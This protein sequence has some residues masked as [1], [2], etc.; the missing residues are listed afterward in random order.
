MTNLRRFTGSRANALF[1]TLAYDPDSHLFL[2]D[3][4]S[5]AFGYLCEPLSAADQSNADRLLVLGNLDWPPETLLQVALWT[6]PDVEETVARMEG[7][8]IET[9]TALLREST[10]RTAAYLRAGSS[11]PISPAGDL[12]LRELQVLVTAK[13]PLAA[14]QPSAHE[15]RDAREL[16]ATAL[17]VLVTAG[18]RPTS[19]TADRHVRIMTTLLNW[20]P[21]AGWRDR[22]TPECDARRPVR[23]QYLD[24]DVGI[25]VDAKGIT[26]GEQRIQTFSVKRFP[27]R[28][29]FGLAA[30][31][32]GDPFSG[33]RGVRHN[34]LITLNL[35]FPDP[36]ATRVTLTS[37]AQWA[38]HQV[39]GNLS[40]YMPRLAHNKRDFDALFARL[41]HG[42]RPLQAYL[43]IVLFTAP[44][45]AAGAASNLRTYWRELGFQVLADRFFVLPL[46]LN[47][48]PFG[49]D[50]GAIR[51]SFRYRT[52]SASHAVA[53]MPVFGDWK[54][55]GTPVLNLIGR[56]GQLVD[57]SLFDSATNYNAVIAASSGS[58]KSFL[59]N[60]LLST[61]LSVGGRC[62]V[63]DVGRSYANL[64][65]SL[66]GQFVAFTADSDIV[67]NPF[68]LLHTWEEEADVIAAM[69]TAM[70]APTE[71]LGDYRTAGLKRA[72]RELWDT[73][74]TAMNVDLIAA[75]MLACAD[76]RLQDVGVQL[77]PFTSR[78]EYG[79]W[80]HGRNTMDFSADLVVLELEELKG[81]KHLQQVIL[82]QLIFQIQQAMYLG[83]RSR[84]KLVLIDEAWDLLTQG[85]VATFI[86]HG[87]RRFRKYNGAAITVTQ[88]LADL[89][90]N[91]TGRAIAENS[92][93]TLLLAQPGHAIDRLKADHRLPMTAAGAE[94]LKTVHTVPGAYSEIMTLTDSGAGIGRLM[95]DP[96][97]Q[98][99]Y[100][101]KPADVAAIRRLR[102]RGMSVEQAINRLL[103]GAETEASDAA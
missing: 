19:L 46:L 59:A 68:E 76:E 36:E 50:R 34:A 47:C 10:R 58:G 85:D 72:L 51:T 99:L 97:R 42:D 1:P 89:Y 22:I 31:F 74:G 56:T 53:L 82:L 26:L 21:Q 71:P 62:W 32:L 84:Q 17:Q 41:D 60:E 73:H 102:E 80:F 23:D 92:A 33:S 30:R 11:A 28:A 8:R 88:S 7:L 12:R 49:A 14:P 93:H 95:V 38:A 65:E 35:Y 91:P 101:T 79:R 69:V 24:Y 54:G 55:T 37:R 52:L 83:E 78:G 57:L 70:A 61:N 15:L 45:E 39:S 3:D 103:A 63:I 86:E 48:L 29:G 4:Q 98:L 2:L 90:A 40:H 66:G 16:Q 5:L 27:D 77:Y 87:Y 81:R 18:M 9:A 43:G 25:D 96:F 100:S 75:A 67:L 64:C 13:L 20:G 6:S 44:E 94:M